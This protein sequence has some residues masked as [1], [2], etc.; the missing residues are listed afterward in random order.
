VV[1]TRADRGILFVQGSLCLD[2]SPRCFMSQHV[3]RKVLPLVPP[4][5]NATGNSPQARRFKKRVAPWLE[6]LVDITAFMEDNMLYGRI[7][8]FNHERIGARDIHNI[9]KPLFDTL[10]NYIYRDDK[11]IKYF[12]GYRLDMEFNNSYFEIELNLSQEPELEKVLFETACLIEVGIL[13]IIPSELIQVNW[14]Q[15]EGADNEPEI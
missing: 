4:T 1:Q 2:M 13:P 7:Y 5:S 11:Q 10:E 12:E 8:Y 15:L 9:I 14:L 3:F 6:E